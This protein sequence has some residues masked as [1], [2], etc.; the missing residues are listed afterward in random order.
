MMSPPRQENTLP[1]GWRTVAVEGITVYI[2]YVLACPAA[3]LLSPSFPP[4]FLFGWSFDKT[5]TRFD[6]SGFN[7]PLSLCLQRV[8]A[9]SNDCT[10]FSQQKTP[11]ENNKSQQRERYIRDSAPCHRPPCLLGTRCRPQPRRQHWRVR[12]P[13]VRL[14]EE[15]A[16][17]RRALGESGLGSHKTNADEGWGA[18]MSFKDG[19]HTH[20][21]TH[22]RTHTHS[23]TCTSDCACFTLP[24]HQHR[25]RGNRHEATQARDSC[26][27]AHLF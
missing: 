2:K 10:K 15:T 11:K 20:A 18:C 5:R 4:C 19:A 13:Q 7:S 6:S 21:H 9:S 27:Y 8:C 1:G 12:L 17:L 3:S 26:W 14:Q 23:H 25:H 24:L 22:A 16:F